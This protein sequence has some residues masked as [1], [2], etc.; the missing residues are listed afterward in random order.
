MCRLWGV[1]S[2]WLVLSGVCWS[3]L[4]LGSRRGFVR[5]DVLIHFPVV[6]DNL[7]VPDGHSTGIIHVVLRCKL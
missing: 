5:Q 1:L 7:S 4:T 6:Q 3:T 2:V